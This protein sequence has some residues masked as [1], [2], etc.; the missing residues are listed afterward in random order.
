LILNNQTTIIFATKI[1]L[2][3]FDFFDESFFHKSSNTMKNLFLTFLAVLM[4]GQVFAQERKRASPRETAELGDVK[5]EYSRPY[6]KGREV[7]GVLVPY[8]QVWRLGADE[9]T[10]ITFKKDA[11]FGGKKVKAGTY[12]MFAIPGEKEWEIILNSELKQWGAYNYDKI[13]DKDVVKVKVPV[14]TPL[15][16]A[17]QFTITPYA[18][19]LSILWDNVAVSVPYSFTGAAQKK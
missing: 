7:F 3:R 2:V 11:T 14:A 13:K 1:I 17:E 5:V 15:A 19:N 12:S 9:A 8:N 4:V 10:E 6:K 18:D 16:S